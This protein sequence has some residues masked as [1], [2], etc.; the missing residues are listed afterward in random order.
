MTA[1]SGRRRLLR[2]SAIVAAGLLALLALESIVNSQAVQLRL[3]QSSGGLALADSVEGQAWPSPEG[4]LTV[5]GGAQSVAVARLSTVELDARRS[6][7]LILR[8]ERGPGFVLEGLDEQNEIRVRFRIVGRTEALTRILP[9][10]SAVGAGS[11][12]FRIL[13]KWPT[14]VRIFDLSL[15]EVPWIART[16][17]PALRLAAPVLLAL[18]VSVHRRRL[19]AHFKAPETAVDYVLAGLIFVLT[20]LIFDSGEVQQVV[21][22]KYTTAV[23]HYLLREG[24]PSVPESLAPRGSVASR[25][26]FR[27]QVDGRLHHYF[28]SAPMLLNAPFVWAYEKLGVSPIDPAGRFRRDHEL[29]ILKL[30]STLLAA[31]LCATLYGLGRAFAK[32]GVALALVA[33]FALGTQILSTISRPFWSHSWAVLLLGGGLALVSHPGLRESRLTMTLCATLLSWSFFCRA[34]MSLSIVAITVWLVAGKAR[35]LGYYVGVGLAWL[36]AAIV[37]S[38]AVFGTY[39]PPYLLSSHNARVGAGA[40]DGRYVDGVLGTLFSP[41]RGLFVFIPFL[42]LVLWWVVRYWRKL[43]DRTLA[44]C[45][46]AVIA[47]HWQLVSIL[48]HWWG[49]QSYGP[50]LFADVVPWWFVLAVLGVSVVLR[51]ARAWSGARRALVA[52]TAALLVAA[53]VFINVRGAFAREAWQWRSFDVPPAWAVEGR[54]PLLEPGGLWNWRYPQFMGGLIEPTEGADSGRDDE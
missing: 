36:A 6:Y 2:D 41:G 16:L 52:T 17:S 47:F 23:T 35:H 45:G 24:T 8:A 28:Y 54:E 11:L 26:Q 1:S 48:R 29:R 32:P 33:V 5:G 46:L 4:G 53:S 43:E 14:E 34:P 44:A 18:F 30:V 13:N 20:F 21:D 39:L 40:A 27:H 51:E 19:L 49:G 22:H 12:S 38:Q 15:H 9:I 42:I 3:I 7:A 31:L 10:E 37:H 25:H 50:R